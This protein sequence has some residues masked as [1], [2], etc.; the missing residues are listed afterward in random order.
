[1]IQKIFKAFLR[2]DAHDSNIYNSSSHIKNNDKPQY[3]KT[4]KKQLDFTLT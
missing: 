3:F 1:M 4:P 2:I